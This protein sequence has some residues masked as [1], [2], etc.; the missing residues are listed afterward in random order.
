[1]YNNTIIIIIIIIMTNN[2]KRHPHQETIDIIKKQLASGIKAEEGSKKVEIILDFEA[3]K[4][5]RNNRIIENEVVFK[6]ILWFL[7]E[8]R[9]ILPHWQII[10]ENLDL[11][12]S[13]S[14]LIK[15]YIEWSDENNFCIDRFDITW[16]NKYEIG[17]NNIG[18][19]SW[20]WAWLEFT[21]NEKWEIEFTNTILTRM[22]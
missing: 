13:I 12:I 21:E 22:S 8:N 7:I 6:K 4:I 19:L 5:N 3:N 20:R 10:P 15:M 17:Y 16:E 1:M 11:E 18:F 2:P 9:L 14:E